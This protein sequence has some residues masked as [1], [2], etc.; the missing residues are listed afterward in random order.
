[1]VALLYRRDAEPPFRRMEDKIRR[2]CEQIRAEGGDQKSIP[3]IVELRDVLHCYVQR[4]RDKLASYP[5]P[6]E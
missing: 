4:L 1:M 5:A 3:R 6:V 2:L